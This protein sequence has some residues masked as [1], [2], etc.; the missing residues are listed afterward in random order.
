MPLL[1]YSMYINASNYTPFWTRVSLYIVWKIHPWGK[2]LQAING[3]AMDGIWVDGWMVWQLQNG[4]GIEMGML[5][6]VDGM[7]MMGGKRRKWD[8]KDWLKWFIFLLA[9]GRH[10][11]P[12]VVED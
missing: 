9:H 6:N 11:L 10:V 4:D 3:V 1:V 2:H 8:G 7:G 5:A 12:L